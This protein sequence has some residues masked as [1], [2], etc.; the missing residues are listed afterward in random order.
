MMT[1]ITITMMR[2]TNTLTTVSV[3]RKRQPKKNEVDRHSG[4]SDR[5]VI[6]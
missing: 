4:D 5:H 2:H 1:V 6:S 3:C